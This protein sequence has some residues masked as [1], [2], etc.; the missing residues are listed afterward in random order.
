M[1]HAH[2]SDAWR[3]L[4]RDAFRDGRIVDDPGGRAV[5]LWPLVHILWA[6][7]DLRLLGDDVQIEPLH[8]LLERFRRRD[9]YA[10]TPRERK[11]YFDDNAWLGLAA[12]R[13][14]AATQDDR[15]PELARQLAAFVRTGEH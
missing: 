3:A 12:L 5:S 6:A 13:L 9:A 2:A 10:A 7:A 15:W 14:R 11:R 4:T 1:W 8:A